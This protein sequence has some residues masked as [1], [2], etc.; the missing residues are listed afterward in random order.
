MYGTGNNDDDILK[1]Y[2]CKMKFLY[3]LISILLYH[4]N[5]TVKQYN[6]V[7]SSVFLCR[8]LLQ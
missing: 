3:Y 5:A 6:C 7:S 4:C 2:V 8:C 1:K